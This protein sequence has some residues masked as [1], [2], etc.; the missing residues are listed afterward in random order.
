MWDALAVRDPEAPVITN[1]KGEPE[2]HPDLRDKENVPLP[3][4]R[5]GFEEDVSGRLRTI[6]YR[7]AI[8]DHLERE[9]HPSVPDAWLDYSKTRIATRSP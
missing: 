7:T 3:D 2:P 6:E 8:D 9:V 4:I 1:R 5:V